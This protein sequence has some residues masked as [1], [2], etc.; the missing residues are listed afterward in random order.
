MFGFGYTGIIASMK[1]VG[2]TAPLL[3]DT[4]SG[5]AFAYSLRKLST[6][7]SGNAIRV[8]RSSDNAEQNIGFVGN[9]LDTASLSSFIG[10][11]SGYITT[12]YDQSGG[13]NNATQVSASLQARI[14][15]SGTIETLNSNPCFIPNGDYSLTLSAIS[16]LVSVSRSNTAA[17]TPITSYG[18]S[19]ATFLTFASNYLL[20]FDGGFKQLSTVANNTRYLSYFNRQSSRMYMALN[21]TTSADC[22]ASSVT[23]NVNSLFVYGGSIKTVEPVQEIISWTSEQSSNESGIKTNINTYYGIY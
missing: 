16:C 3:L 17:Y 1:K 8:R 20:F 7:Y 23:F 4:Y 11:S 6:T 22:G 13:G 18:T 9:V 21:G 5:S 19:V 10:S 12:L 2:G 15:N 14:V